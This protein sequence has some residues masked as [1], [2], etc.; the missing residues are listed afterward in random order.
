MQRKMLKILMALCLALCLAPTALAEPTT[1]VQINVGG[2]QLTTK[3]I[4]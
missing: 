4:K 1:V 3:I 2:G